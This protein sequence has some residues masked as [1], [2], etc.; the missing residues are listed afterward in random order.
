MSKS[1]GGAAE[2]KVRFLAVLFFLLALIPAP[3]SIAAQAS[4]CRPD[5]EPN[6]SEAQA[7]HVES[8]FCIAGD[9]PEAADQDLFL[10]TVSETDAKS[11]WTLTVDGPAGVVT[12][13]K[14]FNLSSAP[15]VE[16]V[17]AD[18]KI[19]EINKVPESRAPVTGDFLVAPGQYLVGIS[20][21]DTTSST[22]PITTGYQLSLAKSERLPKRRDKEPNDDATTASKLGA[23]FDTAGDLKDSDDYYAWTLSPE[24]AGSGWELFAQ[25]ALGTS[26]YLTITSEDGTQVASYSSDSVARIH[27]YDLALPAGTYYLHLGS[28]TPLSSPY[29]MR[30]AR[31]AR[32]EFDLE[33]NDLTE[34]AVPIDL[35]KPVIKGRLAERNDRDF[36]QLTVDDNLA[37]SLFDIRFL[38][39]TTLDRSV[40]LSDPETR[41]DLQCKRGPGGASLSNMLLPRGVYVISVSGEPDPDQPYI[42]RIDV[43]TPP[44]PVYETEPNDLEEFASVLDPTQP[45]QGRFD[46][47]EWDVFRVTTSGDPQLWDVTIT[48][49]G[50]QELDLSKRDGTNL[51]RAQADVNT[52]SPALYDLYLTPGDHWIR[53]YG[54]DGDYTITLTPRG[55]PPPDG[56]HETNNDVNYAEPMLLGDSK[57]GRI[58]TANDYDVFRFSLAA[59]EHVRIQLD[60]PDDGIFAGDARLG[61]RARL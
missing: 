48:G 57:S 9:L 27:A 42:L 34:T 46:G 43:T 15:G 5:V 10:W 32:P 4:A 39:K 11:I 3:H 44:S 52:P 7:E 30:S 51:A 22:P 23:D 31:T 45:I 1:G 28:S 19:A 12:G 33:P 47:T 6:N 61:P 55:P 8:A 29:V 54:A 2:R 24:D 26:L 25:G 20:R 60:V 17:V 50:V 53:A 38:S 14:I 16:P 49:T 36:Y 56:E 35:D 37:G 21:T 18:Q 40:C 13:A 41:A 58:V 59:R